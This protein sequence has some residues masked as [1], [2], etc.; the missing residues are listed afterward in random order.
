MARLNRLT[1]VG[2]AD[3]G[4][5][6]VVMVRQRGKWLPVGAVTPNGV[7]KD[8]EKELLAHGLQPRNPYH[9]IPAIEKTGRNRR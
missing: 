6:Q 9:P 8:A 4:R 7:V 5:T 3:L 2:H 1:R